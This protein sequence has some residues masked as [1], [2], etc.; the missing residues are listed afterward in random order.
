MA[1]SDAINIVKRGGGRL[2]MS[3]SLPLTLVTGIVGVIGT[4]SITGGSGGTNGVYPVTLTGGVLA[5]NGAPATVNVTVAAGAVS[6]VTVTSPGAYTAG[7]PPTA[8]PLTSIPGLTGASFASI[9]TGQVAF[10]TWTPPVGTRTSAIRVTNPVLVAGSP[11]NVNV[12]AGLTPLGA[13]F[14]AAVDLKAAG[15]TNLTL[16]T[17]GLAE[18]INATGVPYYFSAVVVG[19]TVGVGVLTLEVFHSPPNPS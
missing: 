6:A 1:T 19:V 2:N 9:T 3:R 10:W 12:S 8:I 15:V 7:N 4:G 5:T 17:A 16:V 14:V 11:T 18:L 13:D